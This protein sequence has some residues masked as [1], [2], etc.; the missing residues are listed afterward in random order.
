MSNFWNL[1]YLN[2]SNFVD[3]LIVSDSVKKNCVETN[4]DY[5]NIPLSLKSD[6]SNELDIED[7]HYISLQSNKYGHLQINNLHKKIRIW[8][9]ML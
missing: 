9:L 7:K 4:N 6:Y 5:G 1:T 3:A 2:G 8:T